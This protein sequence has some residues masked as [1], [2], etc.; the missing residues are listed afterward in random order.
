[1]KNNKNN[2]QL[3]VWNTYGFAMCGICKRFKF[4]AKIKYFFRCIKWSKQRVQRGFSDDD[5][6]N[7]YSH[8]EE[9]IRNAAAFKI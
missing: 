5:V 6:W 9:L 3:N 4:L 1:M 2:N 8:L 7:M